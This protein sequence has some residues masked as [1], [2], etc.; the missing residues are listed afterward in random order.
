MQMKTFVL[1]RFASGAKIVHVHGT[2]Q[3][4]DA[5]AAATS[6]GSEVKSWTSSG[7]V[8]GNIRHFLNESEDG[9]YTWFLEEVEAVS[10]RPADMDR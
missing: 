5:E 8:S 4:E 2:I 6:I 10:S 7:T 9:S 3:A 1:I